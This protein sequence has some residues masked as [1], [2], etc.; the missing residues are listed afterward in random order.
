MAGEMIGFNAS[1]NSFGAMLVMLGVV[2]AGL[3]IQRLANR[4]EWGWAF[5]LLLSLA[6]AAWVLWH[7]NSRTALATPLLAG[8]LFVV[9]WFARDL[10]VR[11]RKLVFSGAV[12]TFA[13]VVGAVVA[14][15]ISHGTLFH[16]SLT[17]RWKYWVG[18]WRVFAQHV[19]V[20]V[21]F[22]NFGP[23]YLGVRLPEAAEEI[24][25]PHNFIVRIFVELGA[26][27]GLLLL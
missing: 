12:L 4:D 6:P 23:H 26:V 15:G 21:G 25:D 11:H 19:L 10:L 24:N 20:G 2:T 22:A 5:V 8:M 7:T 27:G 3:A 1:P 17:F 9:A 16:D 18:A 13:I 14:H